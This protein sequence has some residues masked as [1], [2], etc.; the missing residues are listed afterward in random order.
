MNKKD[1]A[2]Y[3]C[4]HKKFD[5]KLDDE[6]YALQ[7]GALGKTDLGYLKD[8]TGNN[9]SERNPN[10]CELT[11]LYWI[12]KNSDFDIVG[13]THYRRYFFRNLFDFKNKKVLNKAFIIIKLEK[14]DAILP[15]KRFY[16]ESMY[17]IYKRDHHIN[18]YENIREIIKKVSPEYLIDFD[19]FSKSHE[20]FLY[21]MFICRKKLIDEYCDWLFKLLFELEKCTNIDSY[22]DY[23]KRI[24]GFLSER[25]FNVW[26]IHNKLRVY[27]CN[28]YNTENSSFFVQTIKAPI[29]MK[30]KKII[31]ILGGRK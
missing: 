1:V 3:V 23:N 25:L 22:D 4:T 7:V 19:N 12:W 8:S 11:G 5:Y 26:I 9:I 18:D 15:N 24:Y 13:L 2:I 20:C 31:Y 6:Y 17:E 28:V 29:G 30:L 14:Y 10:Y 16:K 27:E 21:N